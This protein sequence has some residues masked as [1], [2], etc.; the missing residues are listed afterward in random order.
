MLSTRVANPVAAGADPTWGLE[1]GIIAGGGD[2]CP[3]K[4]AE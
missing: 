1:M 2:D 4:E 3:S